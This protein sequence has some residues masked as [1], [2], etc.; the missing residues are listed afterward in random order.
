MKIENAIRLFESENY[1][2]SIELC[3]DILATDPSNI[4]AN[5][6]SGQI[7]V[8][9]ENWD[10]AKYFFE[11]ILS[12]DPT[13]HKGRLALA[14]CLFEAGEK[15]ESFTQYETLL[16][17]AP[18]AFIARLKA[19]DILVSLYRIDEAIEQYQTALSQRPGDID[20][21]IKLSSACK[22]N[23]DF[24]AAEN[25]LNKIFELVEDH[26]I[27]QW[28]W[29]LL[30]LHQGNLKEGFICY[31]SRWLLKNLF[32]PK[33]AG[34]PWEGEN[35]AGKR[36][37]VMA[38]QGWGDQILFS[39]YVELLAELGAEVIFAG[40]PGST[41]LFASLSGASEIVE[42]NQ[43]LPNY[44][45]YIPLM[46]LPRMFETQLDNVPTQVPYLTADPARS[47]FWRQKIGGVGQLKVGLAWRET[48]GLYPDSGHRNIPYSTF[49]K[50]PAIDDIRF[51]ALPLPSATNLSVDIE[52]GCTI[53]MPEGP[54]DQ[55]GAFFDTMAIID[56][57]DLV[58]A[59]D[60]PFVNLAG[61][62]GK[63]TWTLIDAIA[64]WRW[65]SKSDEAPWYPTMTLYRQAE[66]GN[67]DGVMERVIADL[68]KFDL[69]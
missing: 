55:E 34:A 65:F 36:I 18:T 43:P 47:D 4:E 41:K 9:V 42:R 35:L 57:L 30:Q 6:L 5:Y 28:N 38:E 16:A 51:F 24:K 33:M 26:P 62:M 14:E 27:A 39:R 58:I 22:V 19:G 63:E 68:K 40:P 23:G 60:S 52:S 32:L 8:K 45:F 11:T 53:E 17:S 67:W 25:W 15:A 20:C 10:T 46:S 44:D 56:N 50:I 2:D 31:E 1:R 59:A 69:R 21:M 49:A 7:A 66:L 3:Q 61:A 54:I 37:L 12:I 64:D 13:F 29:S 48:K